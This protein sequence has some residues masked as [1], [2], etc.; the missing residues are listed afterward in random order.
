VLLSVPPAE[1][2]HLLGFDSPTQAVLTTVND[3][4][5]TSKRPK[6]TLDWKQ[7]RGSLLVLLG[8]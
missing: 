3:A 5:E 7:S 4:S 1:E 8:H 2:R 6:S